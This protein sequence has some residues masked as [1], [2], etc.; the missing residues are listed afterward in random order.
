MV[1]SLVG[2]IVLSTM[3]S[4]ALLAQSGSDET[5]LQTIQKEMD[6]DLAQGLAGRG[7][8]SQVEALARKFHVPAG[9][10]EDLRNR[11][12][13][14]GAITIE[15]AMAQHLSKLDPISYRTVAEALQRVK[16]LRDEGKGWGAV[17]KDLGFK[18]GPVV[19]DVQHA[20]Q[21]LRV[22]GERLKDQLKVE[23]AMEKADR[24]ARVDRSAQ[25]ERTSRPE[26]MERPERPM[27]P[28]RSGR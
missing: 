19:S 12:Q 5:Q 26:R 13:G 2:V 28:E 22:E 17:A 18:L 4:G 15:L 7:P 10:V 6:K 9:T 25:I 20:R 3:F 24:T 11:K 21:E 16:S 23:K 1:V 14:W 27:R 8:K